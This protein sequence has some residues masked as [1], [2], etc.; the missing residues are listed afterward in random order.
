MTRPVRGDL[1]GAPAGRVA[2]VAAALV[3]ALGTLVVVLSARGDHAVRV[4][5]HDGAAWLVSS[6]VGQAALV[7]GSSAQVVTQ[8]PVAADGA[9]LSSAQAGNDA[10]VADGATGSLVRVDGATYDVSQPARFAR[11][12]Q[13]L[14][15]FPGSPDLFTFAEGSGLVTTADI[16]SL[17][18]RASQ[19]LVS[20]IAPGGGV[21]DGDGRLWL[22]EAGSGDLVWLERDKVGR[23]AAAVDPDGSR[24]VVAAGQ[25]A[26]VDG[27]SV[28]L[29]GVDG[30]LGS[31]TCLGESA[32]DDTAVVTGSPAT[33]RLYTVSGRG[34]LLVSD[35]TRRTCD[36]AVDL[37]A[38]GHELGPPREAAGRVFVPDFT[39]GEVHVVD[40]TRPQDVP[41]VKVLRPHTRFE[42][43][44]N[45][46]FM[47]FND[48][49]SELAGVVRLNGSAVPIRK[50]DPRKPDAG[51][52]QDAGSQ[53]DGPGGGPVS[54]T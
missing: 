6:K 33:S 20:R 32:G 9:D 23:R 39:T 26:V 21:V 52:I 27:T 8:V 54:Y 24:L 34:V 5:M 14:L 25:A 49:A 48:P 50:Y 19:A 1:R 40:L 53:G 18:P 16:R 44:P 45:G 37:G 42:L 28:R 22:I 38:G 51:I 4:S 17:R 36:A 29:L 10:F 15:V 2:A 46:S 7:D 41:H 30:S 3:V 43:V 12:G 11:P 31:A 35:L 13:R 47:F